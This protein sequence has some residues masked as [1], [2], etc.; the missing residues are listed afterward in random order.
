MT[1]VMLEEMK[2][3]GVFLISFLYP[4]LSENYFYDGTLGDFT[5]EVFVDSDRDHRSW[6]E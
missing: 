4:L 6:V 5:N 1:H 3:Q 2:E